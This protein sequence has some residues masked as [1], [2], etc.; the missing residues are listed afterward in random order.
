MTY[1]LHTHSTRSDG[2]TAPAVTAALAA[3]AGLEGFALTDHDT[4][5][6]WEEAAAAAAAAGIAFVPGVEL[7]TEVD[8]QSVH[9]LGYWIDP[10]DPAL[11]A[12]CARL[13][14]ERRDRARRIVA[15][16]QEL[17]VGIDLADVLARA[18][19][20]PVG[21]PHIAA[22]LVAVGAVPDLDTAF[23]AYLA[24]GGPA[25]VPKHALDPADGVALIREAGGVA[26]LAHP[27]AGERQAPVTPQLV[28]RLVAAGLAGVE[29]D[30]PAHDPETVARWRRVAAAHDL[31]A[32][33]SSDF[34]GDHKDVKIGAGTTS[35]DALAA[36]WERRLYRGALG[37]RWQR[38]AI[39]A[40]RGE[41]GD[42]W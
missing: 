19:S 21:R 39:A 10:E 26:V 38:E 12:E 20:A 22:E 33:G 13:R 6:G 37:R 25:Y 18:G 31:V 23:T 1:D 42:R 4:T 14:D 17:G 15:R 24:D 7:S 16:L 11:V 27:G 36:L 3:E 35:A 2:T 30:H 9:L 40:G 28:E 5:D 41:E 8:E 29:T 34:H 32:T